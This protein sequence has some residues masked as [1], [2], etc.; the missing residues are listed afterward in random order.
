MLV[1]FKPLA[2]AGTL[3]LKNKLHDCCIYFTINMTYLL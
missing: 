3:F 2:L 1:L